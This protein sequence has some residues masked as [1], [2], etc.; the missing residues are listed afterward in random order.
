VYAHV[1]PPDEP[2][3]LQLPAEL[4]K[5]QLMTPAPVH[6]G[7]VSLHHGNTVHQSGRNRSTSWRRACA[8]HYVRSDVEFATPALPYDHALKLRV[9]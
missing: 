6:K 1:A 2:F 9:S 7:G 5:K 4:A 3:N 8:L